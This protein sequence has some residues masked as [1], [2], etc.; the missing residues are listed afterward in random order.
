[1]IAVSNP[2]AGGIVVP[3]AAADNARTCDGRAGWIVM[4][5]YI[6]V[7]SIEPVVAPLPAIACHIIHAAAIGCETADNR[8]IWIDP[9][10]P[11]RMRT[12]G[13]ADIIAIVTVAVA[14]CLAVRN[15]IAPGKAIIRTVLAAAGGIFPFRLGWKAVSVF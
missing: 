10:I 12:P 4:Q 1:M 7:I 15:R 9:V 2:A 8:G 3:A 5:T 14:I 11:V 13:R 6:I